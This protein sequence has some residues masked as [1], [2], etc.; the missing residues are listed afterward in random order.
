MDTFLWLIWLLNPVHRLLLKLTLLVR[1]TWLFNLDRIYHITELHLYHLWNM[2][3]KDEIFRI[4]P[5]AFLGFESWG[6]M[7]KV[8]LVSPI[9]NN[10]NSNKKADS[11]RFSYFFAN[12]WCYFWKPFHKEWQTKI[13]LPSKCIRHSKFFLLR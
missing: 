3:E 11:F 10:S 13:S 4:V 6:I 1:G 5:T 12:S 7:T 9:N 2:P 8:F